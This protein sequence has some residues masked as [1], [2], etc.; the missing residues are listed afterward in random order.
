M[1]GLEMKNYNELQKR[2]QKAAKMSALSSVE[3]DKYKYL[4]DKEVLPYAQKQLIEQAKFTYSPLGKTFRKQTKTIK[5]LRDKQV[6][7]LNSLQLSKKQLPSIIK[8]I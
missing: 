8:R 5:D 6:D 2:L 7:A 4:T 1:I 3:I